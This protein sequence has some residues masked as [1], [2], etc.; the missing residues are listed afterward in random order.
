VSYALHYLWTPGTTLSDSTIKY[1]K[2]APSTNTTYLVIANLGKCQ[3]RASTYVRVVPYPQVYAGTDTTICYG[4]TIS[5]NG[6]ITAAYFTWAPDSSLTGAQTLTPMATP[7]VT[8]G[9]TLT[10]TDTLGCPKPVTASILVT[11][12][13]EVIVNP[14][15]DTAVVVGEPL[16]LHAISTDSALVSFTWDPATWLNDATIN[17]P[18]AT[19]TSSSVDSVTYL[20][21]AT[22]PQGCTGSGKIRVLVYKTLPDIFVPN[23]FTPNGDGRNEVFRPILVGIRSLDYFRIYNRWGQLVFA[24]SQN[25]KGWDGTVSGHKEDTGTF[26]YMIQGK[27]YLGKVHVKK[28]TFV[29]VR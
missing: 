18:L 7:L 2:A 24:T 22:T 27:D 19:I 25:E 3:A 6:S 20:V 17:D 29:L 13:P 15:N 26:V 16:Q 5:L 4:S 28:G 9:Y 11:V 8:T 12:I 23:A 1:P 14:G 10:V 21:T